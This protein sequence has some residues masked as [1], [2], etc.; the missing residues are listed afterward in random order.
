MN[1]QV[2]PEEIAAFCRRHHILRMA[3]FGSVLRD[4]FGPESDVDVL[5]EFEPEHVPGWNIV[6]MADELS[7]ILEGRRVD[8][9]TF[10]GLHLLIRD[11][12][13]REA[14]DVYAA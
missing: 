7:C 13:L 3:F 10:R 1:I 4:D 5:V 2:K 8:L 14:R 6:S 11:Q 12:V 9:L